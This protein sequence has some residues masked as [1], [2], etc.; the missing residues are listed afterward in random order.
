MALGG[1]PAASDQGVSRRGAFVAGPCSDRRWM[2]EK[3][4]EGS[5]GGAAVTDFSSVSA[6]GCSGRCS[7][8]LA[9]QKKKRTGRRCSWWPRRTRD[10]RAAAGAA[11]AKAGVRLRSSSIGPAQRSGA[12]GGSFRIHLR[13]RASAMIRRGPSIWTPPLQPPPRGFSGRRR[14]RHGRWWRACT[15]RRQREPRL[16]PGATWGSRPVR[17]IRASPRRWAKDANRAGSAE[18]SKNRTA[19]AFLGTARLAMVP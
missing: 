12:E 13:K 9:G 6:A 16:W 15:M 8:G 19:P 14:S 11:P 10:R 7:P 2:I 1:E 17:R 5:A 18:W 4:L 3:G